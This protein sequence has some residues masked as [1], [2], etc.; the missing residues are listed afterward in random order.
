MLKYYFKRIAVF[1]FAYIGIG[2]L[3]NLIIVIKSFADLDTSFWMLTKTNTVSILFLLME[4]CFFII[5]FIFYLFVL[6]A[7]KHNGVLDKYLTGSYFV[8]FFYLISFKAISEYF[9]WDEFSSRFNFI[10]VDYLIYTQEVIA[11]IYE[12]YP[13]IPILIVAFIISVF[14][15]FIFRNIFV[16]PGTK[17]PSAKKRLGVLILNILL[18]VI[19]V[20]QSAMS[21]SV[22]SG[23][24]YNN[25]LASSGAY[26]FVYAFF[27]N[28]IDYDTFYITLPEKKT[29]GIIKNRLSEPGVT[30]KQ[31]FVRHIKSNKPE[32]KVNVIFV[33]MESMGAKYMDDIKEF[34]EPESAPNLSKFSKAGIYFPHAYSTGTRTVRGIE[35][36]TVSL[37][38][39]PGMSIVRR[40]GNENLHSI[41]SIFRERGYTTQFIYGGFGYFDNMNYYFENN[42]FEVID[43]RSFAED[44]ITFANAWGVAD[45]N[46]FSRAIKEA[47]K[48]YKAKK[49]F[50]QFVLTTSNHRPYTYPE[51]TVDV[52]SGTSRY[53]A[54]KYADYSVG[55]LVEEA[56]KK[57]WFD[58]TVFVFVADHGP[59][60]SGKQDLSAR[61][62]RIPFIVYA[63]KI[64][65]PKRYEASISQIDVAP[66]LLSLLNFS[67]DSYFFGNDATQKNYKQRYFLNNYQKIGYVEDDI[68][69]ILKPV[70]DVDFYK[71]TELDA[72]E[73][74]EEYT[75][76]LDAAISYYQTADDWKRHLKK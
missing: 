73:H 3:V 43:R 58:E 39:L 70:K 19:I 1:L 72:Q 62:H 9:F 42:G 14:L 20:W 45:E 53:G 63:P 27:N 32:K 8:I 61:E 25:E 68:M 13:I 67:Y 28:E 66:T 22:I 16:F 52:P 71:G 12:S 33:L 57:P 54:V 69:T 60:S 6:P 44:E 31:N 76:Y 48:A 51:G 74:K 55:K 7:K 50:F 59:G 30:F 17:V 46:L 5:P 29:E 18:C 40:K 36:V 38:P 11:N 26:S 15:W 2:L 64:F 10:A 24:R 47:D 23:N 75:K 37:P 35:A 21:W 65:K 49:P 4:F 56:S 41:G 34:W